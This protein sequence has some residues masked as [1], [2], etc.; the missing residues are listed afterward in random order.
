[1]HQHQTQLSVTTQ[2]STVEPAG[3]DPP[4]LNFSVVHEDIDIGCDTYDSDVDEIPMLIPNQ[5]W[6]VEEE[7]SPTD[8]LPALVKSTPTSPLTDECDSEEDLWFEETMDQDIDDDDSQ[9]TL[10]AENYK[11]QRSTVQEEED[12]QVVEPIKLF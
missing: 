10:A 4:F 12:I 2:D 7:E 5:V 6:T 8:T 9:I 1:M 3:E 11:H